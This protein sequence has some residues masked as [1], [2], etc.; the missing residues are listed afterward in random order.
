MINNIMFDPGFGEYFRYNRAVSA[1]DGRWW[2][3]EPIWS[4]AIKHGLKSACALWPGS[5][6]A[7][8]G[9][10]PNY[11]KVYDYSLPFEQRL[12][13][14]IGWLHS[15]VSFLSFY[16]EEVNGVGHRSGPGSPEL[17]AAIQLTDTRV[18][19]FLARLAAEKIAANLVIVS[20]HGMTPCSVDRAVV[21]DDY[22]D[23]TK[24]Q[25]DFDETV[26]GLRP[27]DGYTV[28]AMMRDLAKLPLQARAYRAENLPAHLR[29]NPRQPRVPP[30]WILPAEGWQMARR[31]VYE[32][33]KAKFLKGQHGYDPALPSMHGIFIAHGLRF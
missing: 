2:G 23:L 22:L 18:G 9:V 4:T 29:I 31:T 25:I 17:A 3:G 26:V 24:I 20:D 13:E 8:G 6:A 33:A 16:L 27:R 28:G 15:G 11:W 10:R 1:G 32:A 21:I 5:E 7:I 30:V 19:K 14:A 12:D